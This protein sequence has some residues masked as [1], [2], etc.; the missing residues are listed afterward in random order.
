[1]IDFD[2]KHEKRSDGRWNS[3]LQWNDKNK[4][5]SLILLENLV[6]KYINDNYNKKLLMDFIHYNIHC[7]YCESF[8]NSVNG[9]CKNK[10]I[11]LSLN[12]NTQY[13]DFYEK[14]VAHSFEYCLC[15]LAKHINPNLNVKM[16]DQ[17]IHHDIIIG[18]IKID[19]KTKNGNIYPDFNI[20]DYQLTVAFNSLYNNNDAD[21]YCWGIN[22]KDYRRDYNRINY[23]TVGLIDKVNF[24]KKAKQRHYGDIVKNKDGSIPFKNGKPIIARYEDYILY[25]D[26]INPIESILKI[27]TEMEQQYFLF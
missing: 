26:Q 14:F 6:N 4:E 15:S 3:Y 27:P 16:D 23:I 12:R 25:A 2:F 17:G 24:Y 22:S 5:A 13:N 8:F 18:N 9:F 10:N 19:A 1:M 11:N 7:P 20:K 21:Y